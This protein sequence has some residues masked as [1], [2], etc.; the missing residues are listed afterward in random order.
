MFW[1]KKSRKDKAQKQAEKEAQQ[2]AEQSQKIREQALANARAAREALGDET[3]QKITEA[4]TKK[5]QSS[6]E[7]AK[8]DIMAADPDRLLDE[9]KFMLDQKEETD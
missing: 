8:R 6:M 5:Q 9:L 2:A 4:M 3:I 7:Q 1:S